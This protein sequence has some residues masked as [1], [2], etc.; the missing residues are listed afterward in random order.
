MM[1]YPQTSMKI[2]LHFPLRFTFVLT[3]FKTCRNILCIRQSAWPSFALC[4][5]EECQSTQQRDAD[6][7]PLIKD[8]VRI[9]ST[10]YLPIVF[11][12]QRWKG[13]ISCC[14]F[15]MLN[16]DKNT[17]GIN[18]KPFYL[19]CNARNQTKH[20]WLAEILKSV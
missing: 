1:H 18:Q 17:A 20:K 13:N 5:R 14:T 12:T 9:T 7:I 2:C 19:S 4:W 16:T 3:A 15:H 10:S 11:I 8:T 6:E